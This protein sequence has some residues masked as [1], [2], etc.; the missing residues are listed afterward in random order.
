MSALAIPADN[1]RCICSAVVWKSRPV[2]LA[3][4]PVISK[5][6]E[7]SSASLATTA[8]FPAPACICSRL[9]GTLDA[10]FDITS[11]AFAPSSTLPNKNFNRICKDS[12][13]LPTSTNDLRVTP[14][15]IPTRAFLR[16]KTDCLS[17]S[18]PVVADFI[19]CLQD[20]GNCFVQ[21]FG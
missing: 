1:D 14:A 7:S 18:T 17:L 21:P 6:L 4:L 3:T 16:L 19:A 20:F 10:N 9:K 12:T 15:P 2:T 8:R 13:C 5:T 11:K